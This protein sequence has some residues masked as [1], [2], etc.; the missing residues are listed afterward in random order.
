MSA[1]CEQA[2]ERLDAFAD[3]ELPPDV[4][5]D[6]SSHVEHC[7]ECVKELNAIRTLRSRVRA[8]VNS[9]A[10]PDEFQRRISASLRNPGTRRAPPVASWLAV[11]AML[12]LAFGLGWTLYRAGRPIGSQILRIALADHV[13]CAVMRKYPEQPPSRQQMESDM[14]P[15]LKDLIPIVRAR[16]PEQYRLEQAH[17]CT[18]A[19]RQ[20]VHMIFRDRQALL[21]VIATVRR[22]GESLPAGS[23]I[24]SG[25]GEGY[26][27][28][29]FNA[30]TF[31]TYIVS[32]LPAA[33]NR[34]MALA[35][36]RPVSSYLEGLNTRNVF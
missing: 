7:P 14:G 20:Y 9:Q 21:S 11:A 12:A 36:A 23:R 35:L 30:G 13:H 17:R 3:H 4:S 28:A 8:A 27:V 34:T 24:R 31:L 29:A 2:R 10:V 15:L 26:Q 33:E 16:V 25:T 32:D 5:A 19:G 18:V 1:G 6:I 22:P